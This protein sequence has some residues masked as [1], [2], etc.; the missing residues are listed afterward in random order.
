ML[1]R[2]T[3]ATRIAR[4]RTRTTTTTTTRRPHPSP[5]RPRPPKRPTSRA[6]RRRARRRNNVH[7]LMSLCVLGRSVSIIQGPG[8]G[9]EGWAWGPGNNNLG[10]RELYFAGSVSAVHNH[11]DVPTKLPGENGCGTGKLRRTAS[12][13][14]RAHVTRFRRSFF[15]VSPSLALLVRLPVCSSSPTPTRPPHARLLDFDVTIFP[16]DDRAPP[17]IN[18]LE[19]PP[20]RATRNWAHTHRQPGRSR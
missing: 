13:K 15:I 10:S 9:L 20:P 8:R 3:R 16:P 7:E 5:R 4:T 18:E 1:F 17:L 19:P 14:Q 11:L 6:S 2:S 12:S